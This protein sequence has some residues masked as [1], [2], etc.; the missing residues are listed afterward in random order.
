MTYISAIRNAAVNDEENQR[1]KRINN[2]EAHRCNGEELFAQGEAKYVQA[3]ADDNEWLDDIMKNAGKRFEDCDGTQEAF[4]EICS[5]AKKHLT[6][7]T[8]RY[9]ASTDKFKEAKEE[10]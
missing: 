9:D 8:D 10:F 6:R 3:S 7:A 5:D 4:D 2:N 1:K